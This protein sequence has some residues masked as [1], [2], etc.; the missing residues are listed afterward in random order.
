MNRAWSTERKLARIIHKVADNM[1]KLTPWEAEFIES[2]SDQL[3]RNR[4]L[5][6]KQ[7]SI[8]SRIHQER[9]LGW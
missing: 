8:I 1:E 9:I 6:E 5:S 3:D 7:R 2:V 4:E